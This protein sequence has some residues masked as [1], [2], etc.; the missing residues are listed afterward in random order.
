MGGFSPLPRSFTAATVQDDIRGAKLILIRITYVARFAA[1]AHAEATSTSIR[2]WEI[3]LVDDRVILLH[4]L[5]TER[6]IS[7]MY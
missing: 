7:S 5:R 6:Q 2:G 4:P 3:T 1:G